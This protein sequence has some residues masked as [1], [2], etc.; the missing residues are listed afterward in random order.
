MSNNK[1]NRKDTIFSAAL[2]GATIVALILIGI[3]LYKFHCGISN[4]HQTFSEF[5]SY[6]SSITGLLAFIGVLYSIIQSN[7]RAEKNEKELKKR[8]ERSLF[9]KYLEIYQ[10]Q[11]DTLNFSE[12]KGV[13]AFKK[14]GEKA[15]EYLALYLSLDYLLSIDINKTLLDTETPYDT[16]STLIEM[17]Q[18][19]TEEFRDPI[20]IS[21]KETKA[22]EYCKN[23]IQKIIEGQYKVKNI[24]LIN[25]AQKLTTIILPQ[26]TLNKIVEAMKYV[27]NLIYSENGYYLGQYFRTVYYLLEMNSGLL[28]HKKVRTK[29]QEKYCKIFRAQLS[30]YELLLIFYNSFSDKSNA[31]A[32]YYIKENQLFN[33]LNP[34]D[35]IVY[36]TNTQKDF[37]LFIEELLEIH[38]S[39]IGDKYKEYLTERLLKADP[40]L[41]RE[42]SE[43]PD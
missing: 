28:I 29:E 17:C 43:S 41:K 10:R 32:Q 9:F 13:D 8:D 25:S 14:C 27:G 20:L 33:N 7:K 2:V 26:L 4:S 23:N 42:M 34:N 37:L 16:V 30:S 1:E 36:S 31:F 15:N 40:W 12:N 21:E 22:E 24:N 18:E 39:Q 11:V 3:Y 5:G 35:V 19:I 38:K 6:F